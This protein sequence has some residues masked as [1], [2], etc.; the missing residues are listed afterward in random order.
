VYSCHRQAMIGHAVEVLVE[1]Q[2]EETE[3]LLA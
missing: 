2:S 1:G 3:H